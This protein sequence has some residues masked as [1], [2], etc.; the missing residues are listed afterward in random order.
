MCGMHYLASTDIVVFLLHNLLDRNLIF[1]CDEYEPPPL[2][3]LWI[4]WKLNGFNL[5]NRKTDFEA[6]NIVSI[7]LPNKLKFL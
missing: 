4:L 5:H 7:R 3:C 2:F 6:A 1:I